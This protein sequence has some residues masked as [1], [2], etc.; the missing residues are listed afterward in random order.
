[1]RKGSESR[2][3]ANRNYLALLARL[4]LDGRLQS[5]IDASDL[6]QETFLGA[7]RGFAPFRGTT[8]AEL[9]AWLR[10]ILASSLAMVV[11]HYRTQRRDVRLECK[12]ADQLES[13]SRALDEALVAASNSPSQQAARREQA[14][15]LADALERLPEN[16]REVLILRHLQ[17]LT[18]PQVAQRMGRSLDSVAMLQHCARQ[19]SEAPADNRDAASMDLPPGVPLGDYRIVREVGRG[20]MGVVPV[21]SQEQGLPHLRLD[22]GLG[23]VPNQSRNRKREHRQPSGLLGIGKHD[24]IRHHRRRFV[25]HARTRRGH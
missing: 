7:Y 2:R 22:G 24:R 21:R 3:A 8:E 25:C 4:Q 19:L 23:L 14:V 9:I 18:F 5:K 13:S 17:G 6:I 20:G 15:L 1:L 11:R 12:L 10:Q 16:Y